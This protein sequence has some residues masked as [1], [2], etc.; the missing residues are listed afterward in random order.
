M[1]IIRRDKYGRRLM[2]DGDEQGSDKTT[3]QQSQ[4]DTSSSNPNADKIKEINKQIAELVNQKLQKKILFQ[5]DI[6]TFDNSIVQLQKQLAELGGGVNPTTINDCVTYRFSKKLYEAV[7]NRTDEMASMLKL[8]F[9]DVENLSYKPT[10][11]RYRTFA[12]NIISYLNRIGWES[13]DHEEDFRGFMKH[14][15]SA[16]K[17]SFSSREIDDIIDIL[18]EKLNDNPMFSWIFG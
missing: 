3:T 2:E 7:I 5:N 14:L 1:R 10:Q 6:R 9:D 16:S 18:C 4:Q 15:L 13:G 11:T 12:K 17:D 8:S